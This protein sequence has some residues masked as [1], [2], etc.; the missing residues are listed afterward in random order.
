MPIHVVTDDPA[1]LARLPGDAFVPGMVP[2]DDSTRLPM[3]A[4][5]ELLATRFEAEPVVDPGTPEAGAGAGAVLA[6][7]AP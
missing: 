2:D 4:A 7:P 3:S 6:P 1:L 5:R